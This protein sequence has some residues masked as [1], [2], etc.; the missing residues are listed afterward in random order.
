MRNFRAECNPDPKRFPNQDANLTPLAV[1][2]AESHGIDPYTPPALQELFAFAEAYTGAMGVKAD[3]TPEQQERARRVRFDLELKRVPY[4]PEQVGDDFNGDGPGLLERRVVEVVRQCGAVQRTAVRS[5]DHR[6]VRAVRQ[7][8]P[9]IAGGVLVAAV[10]PVSP[11][12]LVRQAEAQTYLP[13][14]EFV[15]RTMVRRLHDAGLRIVPW[16]VNEPDDWDRLLEWGVDGIGTDFPDALA[17]H[18]RTRGIA[19]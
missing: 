6:S 10:V 14:Y 12:D 1:R 19:F 11:A 8:E 5:F 13:L 15:D 9:G 17:L 7:L 16:T 18:L 4:R 2:F 3:K